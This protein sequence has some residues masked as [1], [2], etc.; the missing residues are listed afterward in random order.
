MS[1]GGLTAAA[2]MDACRAA[3]LL[4]PLPSNAAANSFKDT[5]V[6]GSGFPD[7]L[8]GGGSQ[9]KWDMVWSDI[10][11][12]P[13]PPPSP[14]SPPWLISLCPVIVLVFNTRVMG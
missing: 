10:L 13:L 6:S 5:A 1:Q 14:P 7:K 4:L 2:H 8:R 11:K 9:K 12:S 3:I